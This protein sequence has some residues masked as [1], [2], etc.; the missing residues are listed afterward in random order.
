MGVCVIDAVRLQTLHRHIGGIVRATS[1][2][3]VLRFS[4][5]SMRQV[6]LRN[7]VSRPASVLKETL[8]WR[9]D[10]DGARKAERQDRR[11]DAEDE[12][13]GAR[14]GGG[15]RPLPPRARA[16]PAVLEWKPRAPLMCKPS[17]VFFSCYDL[18]FFGG[19]GW[20]RG[21]SRIGDW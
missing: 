16:R 12:A 20:S 10:I 18:R 8:K 19:V 9:Q 15:V 14:R 3:R 1:A 6:Q 7:D 11:I 5:E 4:L 21:A 2:G 13:T 17:E